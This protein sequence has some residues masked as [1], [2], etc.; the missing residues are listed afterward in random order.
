MKPRTTILTALALVCPAALPCCSATYN[1]D[2]VVRLKQ[3]GEPDVN[4][5]ATNFAKSTTSETQMV[6]QQMTATIVDIDKSESRISFAGPNGWSYSPGGVD[7]TEL[8]QFRVG[9]KVDITWNIDRK[10][11]VE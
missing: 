10:V 7:R 2:V 11:S 9:D 8:D 3:P 5:V 4:T 1:N 6:K